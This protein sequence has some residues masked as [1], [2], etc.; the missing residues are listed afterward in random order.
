MTKDKSNEQAKCN[1]CNSIFRHKSSA[2]TSNL[3]RHLQV[4]HPFEL[5][6]KQNDEK[7]PGKVNEDAKQEKGLNVDAP[8]ASSSTESPKVE[9]IMFP[10]KREKIQPTLRRAIEK[11]EPYSATH[12]KKK[13]LDGLVL[14]MI[15]TDLQPLSVVED[16]GFRQLVHALD[17]KYT[18]VSRQHLTQ[19][20]LPAK[21]S[22]EKTKL[23]F[24]LGK[25]DH[26]AITTDQ[27]TSRANDAYTTFTA[28]FID[29][30]WE[31][32]SAVLSTRSDRKRHTAINLS[33]EMKRCLEE[34][35]IT[36]KVSAVVTDNAKNITNAVAL[37]Q[38]ENAVDDRH[39]CFAHTLNLVVR[40]ALDNDAQSNKMI[41]KVKNI[42]TF[43]NSSTQANNELR[44]A[45]GDK[46]RKLKQDVVTRWN[47]TYVMLASYKALHKDI[48]SILAQNNKSYMNLSESDIYLLDASLEVLS[49]NMEST[50]EM[51]C[52]KFTS[53][54]KI[55]PLVTL[56]EEITSESTTSLAK[57]L[58]SQ[59]SDY[60]G[61]VQDIKLLSMTTM[62]DPR[63]KNKMFTNE[64]VRLRAESELREE[65]SKVIP[66]NDETK[67][68]DS[69]TCIEE[70]PTKKKVQKKSLWDK[71]DKEIE[72]EKKAPASKT[73]SMI[74]FD[75][76]IGLERINRK[77]DPLEWWRKHEAHLPR[78]SKL[79][80]KYLAIP[81]TSVPS[82]RVFSKA[83]ELVSARRANLKP[84][85]VDMILFLNK[86]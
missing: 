45:Q 47:S 25:A 63:F 55:I 17:P 16:K 46:Y 54:S 79:A 71:Y 58:L 7:Q 1:V 29:D 18:I 78:L 19:K 82:E 60:F 14:N 65:M 36:H 13:H 70:K 69:S 30:R 22:E 40:H 50:E 73:A 20:L 85:N 42:V 76:Y 8:L 35:K 4:H 72:K 21:Y 61:D 75:S 32:T 3:L 51:S 27:W 41:S 86:R 49:V 33:D 57:K 64:T 26:V 80:K 9:S 15:T 24:D 11:Q 43:F 44:K 53:I 84:K 39:A 5:K 66:I 37:T 12:W 48:C 68:S 6:A 77:E 59:L 62:L 28:H 81:A 31:L 38:A 56:L 2:S 83:G 52:K 34:F 23:L 74:E 10:I 67:E